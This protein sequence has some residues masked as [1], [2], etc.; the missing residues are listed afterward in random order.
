MEKIKVAICDDLSELCQYYQEVIEAQEDMEF[1]GSATNSVDCQKLV[2]DTHPDIL[3]LD[4]QIETNNSGITLIP[5][6]KKISANTKIITIT[7]HEDDEYIFDA[8]AEGA[9]D[10]LL[11]TYP[12]EQIMEIIRNI[13]N[14]NHSLRPEIVKKVLKVCNIFRHQKTSLL[15][16]VSTFTKLSPTELEILRDA[17]DGL[18]YKNIAKKRFVEEITIRAHISRILKKFEYPNMKTLVNDLKEIRVFDLF[19]NQ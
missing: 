16:V 14:D 11:K 8:L 9:E 3:L 7:I 19:K 12:D 17:Y 15:Y 10:Y 4:I 5:I 1:V 13:Y 6:I 2:K 18:S